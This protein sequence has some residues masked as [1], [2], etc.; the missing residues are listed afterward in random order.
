MRLKVLGIILV[1]AAS[2]LAQVSVP[3]SPG[4]LIYT[5]ATGLAA[6]SSVT[7]D[8]TNLSLNGGVLSDANGYLSLAPSAE[9]LEAF[10]YPTVPVQPEMERGRFPLV[11]K[12][13]PSGGDF[14]GM[15]VYRS[16]VFLGRAR[17]VIFRARQ[18]RL[19][20]PTGLSLGVVA[21]LQSPL[22]FHPAKL[23]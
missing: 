8:G 21:S 19:D 1:A 6:A 3:G 16:D 13:R 5:G 15:R 9:G 4:D 11:G 2:L 17:R 22:P 18:H 23:L 7:T 12:F 10:L 14:Q 20:E